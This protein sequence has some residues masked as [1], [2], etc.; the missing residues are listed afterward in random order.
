MTLTSPPPAV[1]WPGQW[2]H[3]RPVTTDADRDRLTFS[4]VNKPA[5][6]NFDPSTGY[7]DGTPGRAGVG[8]Y[9][10]IQVSVTDGKVKVS[11]PAFGFRVP[12]SN[13]A[14]V[15][16]GVPATTAVVG[17]RYYFRPTASDIDYQTLRFTVKN[18]PA[19]LGVNTSTGELTGTPSSS[20]VGL[21]SNIIMTVSDGLTTASL[22]AFAIQ[23][24]ASTS[25]A[26][27][28][29][30][31]STTTTAPTTTTSS[32]T[33][34]ATT[35]PTT[36]T[37]TT[38]T[39]GNIAPV[40]SASAPPLVI[41]PGQYLRYYPV[42]SD[43]NK[44]RLTFSVVNKPAWASFDANTG[45]LIG[46]PGRAGVG[47]YSNIQV[48]VSDGKV[49]VS[50]P[51]FGFRV[52]ESNTAPVI[53]GVPPTNAL[54]GSRYTFRPTASDIDLQT[55]RFTVKNKPAWLSI[56]GTT[57][58]LSGTPTASNV[59]TYQDIIL[60]VSDGMVW[61]SLAPFALRVSSSATSTANEAPT[62]SGVPPA[63]VVQGTGYSFVPSARDS[64]AD[65]LTFS[66]ANKPAWLTFS[67]ADGR[68]TGTPGAA[69]VGQYQ[70]IQISVSDG[71]AQTKL[72]AFAI[73]VV[74]S[75]SAS[76]TVAWQPPTTNVDGSTLTNLAGHRIYYGTNSATLDRQVQV[77]SAGQTSQVISNLAPGTYY[78]AVAA[79]NSSGIEG[80]RSA[81]VGR[82]VN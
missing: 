23:V 45:A 78:V 80:P 35:S 17:T 41:W 34:T 73:T 61:V 40:I 33:T 31:S 65:A 66:I 5:W 47:T 38:S 6:A 30:T 39:T 11:L 10:N 64:D 26:A 77:S 8:T 42:A 76:I 59:G 57:G 28:S 21:Y 12:E 24:A 20:Y 9:S 32:T 55:L 44:D 50:L 43:A 36:T 22:P 14:P 53:S 54:V 49:K 79:V 48:S 60:N 13:T 52:P 72:A 70:N 7:L 82:T 46:T 51:A 63:T 81:V 29:T 18:K 74:Q 1:V 75:G 3:Y 56:N 68:L 16:S 37:T 25:T 71:K 15:I 2:L 67:T 4:I 19:W 69:D 27:T 62:I 58:E